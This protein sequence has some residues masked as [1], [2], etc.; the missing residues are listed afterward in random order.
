MT[1][2]NASPTSF[3]RSGRS[4]ALRIQHVASKA[5]LN[6]PTI[7]ISVRNAFLVSGTMQNSMHVAMAHARLKAALTVRP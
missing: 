7:V 5:A 2:I 3:T 6:A 4:D 1:A